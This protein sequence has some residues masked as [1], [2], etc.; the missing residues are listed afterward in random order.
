[1]MYR[2]KF[3]NMLLFLIILLLLIPLH[4]HKPPT[5]D[6][7]NHFEQNNYFYSFNLSEYGINIEN[8]QKATNIINK[9]FIEFLKS[10][11]VIFQKV[12]DEMLDVTQKDIWKKNMNLSQNH[13]YSAEAIGI[14]INK[15]YLQLNPV[16]TINNEQIKDIKS[17]DGITLFVP[18]EYRDKEDTIKQLYSRKPLFGLY[19]HSPLAIQI[20][21]I[22]D[23]QHYKL[24]NGHDI[25]IHGSQKLISKIGKPILIYVEPD[26]ILKNMSDLDK[27][28][29]YNRTI[30]FMLDNCVVK[31]SSSIA[32]SN[33]IKKNNLED[34]V[35]N[36]S[37]KTNEELLKEIH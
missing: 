37:I 33:L 18:Q 5:V 2:K 17:F 3:F 23:N 15:N 24:V 35:N 30:Y 14:V 8:N 21:W 12:A 1:M 4:Y 27:S 10:D 9:H 26:T 19:Q 29:L 20:I 25:A 11:Q 31:A 22:S 28:D 13:R 16:T 7:N 34:I 36:E 32:V 6:K